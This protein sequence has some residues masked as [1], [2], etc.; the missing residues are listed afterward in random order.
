MNI[1]NIDRKLRRD[2]I[3]KISY[4]GIHYI[5]KSVDGIQSKENDMKEY[6]IEKNIQMYTLQKKSYYGIHY[7]TTIAYEY[8]L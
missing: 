1:Y 5:Q 4:E 7:I 6:T 3:Y 8:I 2:T